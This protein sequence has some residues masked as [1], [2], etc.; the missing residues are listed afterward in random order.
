[1][2][3]PV[4]ALLNQ[5][6]DGA[7]SG[8]VARIARVYGPLPASGLFSGIFIP[9]NQKR[10]LFPISF[11]LVDGQMPQKRSGLRVALYP[12]IQHAANQPGRTAGLSAAGGLGQMRMKAK[13][14]KTRRET[15]AIKV[16]VTPAEK[17]AITLKADAYSLS[18]STYLREL[19]LRSTRPPTRRG[20]KINHQGKR[21]DLQRVRTVR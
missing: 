15:T 4:N 13:K 16:W 11:L 10:F 17:A 19:A 18:A 8:R 2:R 5:C 3:Y 12:V 6:F 9:R 1:V 14:E 21:T 7:A 20:E